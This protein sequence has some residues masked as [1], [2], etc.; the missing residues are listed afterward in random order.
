MRTLSDLYEDQSIPLEGRLVIKEAAQTLQDATS[1]LRGESKW[2]PSNLC[3]LLEEQ[4]ENNR[5]DDT[6]GNASHDSGVKFSLPAYQ[7][8]PA[9]DVR[10][11]RNNSNTSYPATAPELQ[12]NVSS[13]DCRF[14]MHIESSD[15]VPSS[16]VR[17]VR[18]APPL[19]ARTQSPDK[20]PRVALVA[21]PD[22][23]HHTTSQQAGMP[24]QHHA[25]SPV[26]QRPTVVSAQPL[27]S[28]KPG[29][30]SH[31]LSAAPQPLESRCGNVGHDRSQQPPLG[32]PAWES[33]DG[34]RPHDAQMSSVEVPQSTADLRAVVAPRTSER[35]R[36]MHELTSLR[37]ENRNLREE[38]GD[39]QEQ[40]RCVQGQH[41]CDPT[42]SVVGTPQGQRLYSVVPVPTSRICNPTTPPAGPLANPI[43]Q[44][45]NRGVSPVRQASPLTRHSSPLRQPRVI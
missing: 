9:S 39:M 22:K 19:V 26:R 42:V 38:V 43:L 35:E 11:E 14:E 27:H 13:T 10:V 24:L 29:R 2:K 3:P 37:E 15:S 40:A 45:T 16:S 18:D 4:F 7:S 32:R 41:A 30:C 6:N 21:S 36:L 25:A 31:A 33:R 34:L 23:S 8:G 44:T 12:P 1:G 28:T 5:D 17:L 20:G